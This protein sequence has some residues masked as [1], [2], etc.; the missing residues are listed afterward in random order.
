MS[1]NPGTE[2]DEDG[3]GG[4]FGPPRMFPEACEGRGS[5]ARE[6]EHTYDL[7]GP[8]VEPTG[9]LWL[10]SPRPLPHVVELEDIRALT[11]DESSEFY[12][13]P[14][15]KDDEVLKWEIGELKWLARQ[16]DEPRAIRGNYSNGTPFPESMPTEFRDDARLRLSDFIQL[17]PPAFG[18]IFNITRPQPDVANVNQQHLLRQRNLDYIADTDRPVVRTGRELARM[19]QDETPGLVHRHALNYLLYKRTELSPVRHARVWMALDITIYTALAAAWWYKWSAPRTHSLRQRPYEYD[20]N[21]NFRVL[22]DDFVDD[23]GVFNKCAREAFCPSP[24][25]PRHPAYPS[26]HSTY[27]AAAS[28]L[29]AH[30]FPNEREQLELLANNIGTARL[31]GGVHWRSDHIAGRRLGRAVASLVIKQLEGDNIPP[32]PPPQV[33]R[34]EAPPPQ[35]VL[36]AVSDGSGAKGTMGK[37]LRDSP[38]QGAAHDGLRTQRSTEFP[39]CGPDQTPRQST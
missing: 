15:P 21:N 26:G 24:G 2:T 1:K 30:F 14:Y 20:R 27:S 32:P 35:P 28:E 17:R 34:G 25:T 16:R 8:Q 7:F 31:W 29:L 23:Q 10:Q 12:I 36:N 5:P 39:E 13:P 22:F 3:V 6:P 33:E 11:E 37:D 19:F 4:E 38:P 9:G 18:S